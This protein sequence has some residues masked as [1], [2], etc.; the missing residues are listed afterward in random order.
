MPRGKGGGGGGGGRGG[1]KNHKGKSRHFTDPREMEQQDEKDAKAREWRKKKG[2]EDSDDE[3]TEEINKQGAV[4]ELPPAGSESEEGSSEEEEARPKGV[5]HLIEIHNPNRTGNKTSRKVTELDSKAS[6]QLSRREREEL[7]KQEAARR[8]QQLH[9][10]GKT[11]EARADLARLALIRKQREE[12]A[13]KKE[14]E[15][16]AREAAKKPAKS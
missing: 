13:K 1:K 14:D 16:L 12:A 11:E 6:T 3:E 4:G 10:E 2:I 8:Y 5:E 9:E 7:E 15:R